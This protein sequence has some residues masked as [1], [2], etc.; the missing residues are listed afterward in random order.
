MKII[1]KNLK[2]GEVSIKI[3]SLDDLWYLSQIITPKCIVKGKTYRKISVSEKESE[4]KQVYIELEAEKVEFREF[5]DNLKVLGKI[6]HS[7][8]DRVQKGEY[9]SFILSAND[10]ITLS[11]EWSSIDF[12]YIIKSSKKDSNIMLV[13]AD[14]GMRR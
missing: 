10:E 13:A 7:S 4:R 14:Y 11:K 6:I 1:K 5:G 9:H 12:E 8:D 3:E 2:N